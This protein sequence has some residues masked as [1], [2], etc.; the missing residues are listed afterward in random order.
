[1]PAGM[2][3]KTALITGALG[4]DG[5][6][7]AEHLLKSGYRVTGLTRPG[8][9][10]PDK[11]ILSAMH[12][13]HPSLGDAAA[14]R[15][16]LDQLRPDEIYH[17]AAVHHSSQEY[18]AGSPLALQDAMLSGNFLATKTLAFAIVE[19]RISARLVFAA[20]S[21][22]FTA[23]IEDHAINECS[24]RKPGT[25]YGHIKSWSMDLL[26]FLR[27]EHG[28]Q[29]SS[30]ILFNHESP[31]R[32]AQFVSRKISRAAAAA[33]SGRP[34]NLDLQNLAARVDWS[35]ARDVVRAL[36]LLGT[37][38]SAEDYVVASGQLRSVQEM[39]ESAFAHVGL[40]WRDHVNCRHGQPGPA[41]AGC[42][43]KLRD[44]L[45]WRPRISFGDM[46]GEMVDHDLVDAGP[47]D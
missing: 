17:L 13:E 12:C 29:A 46:I 22:M 14:M 31:L 15:R 30:A 40:D 4:Q 27:A 47:A 19:T 11:G 45:G 36:H 21:Q 25:F 8:A 2:R 28:L 42:A 9:V 38:T 44:N 6:L 3:E 34:V 1:M 23:G 37:A 18:Q 26:A 39:L 35:S 10:P 5:R 32:G 24:P 41:L 16:L 43:G 33:K 7:L 20:S